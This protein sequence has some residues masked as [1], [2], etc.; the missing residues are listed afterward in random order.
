M[1]VSLSSGHRQLCKKK[2]FLLFLVTFTVEMSPKCTF[3]V[4]LLRCRAKELRTHIERPA[5]LS[6][7]SRF[8]FF[9]SVLGKMNCSHL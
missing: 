7:A 8:C 1:L 4:F 5:F 3:C 6:G 9:V 2:F